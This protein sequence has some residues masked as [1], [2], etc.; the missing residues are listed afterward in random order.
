MGISDDTWA[1]TVLQHYDVPDGG[2][3]CPESPIDAGYA[4]CM[5]PLGSS[6]SPYGEDWPVALHGGPVPDPTPQVV[7]ADPYNQLAWFQQNVW[8]YTSQSS[9]ALPYSPAQ[10][11]PN[12]VAAN[13][14]SDTST[15]CEFLFNIR[16]LDEVEVPVW[17]AG[18]TVMT[19]VNTAHAIACN[20][21]G[22]TLTASTTATGQDFDFAQGTAILDSN[23][24]QPPWGP[25]FLY[26]SLL[27]ELQN[28]DN[29]AQL[30]QVAPGSCCMTAPSLDCSAAVTYADGQTLL[31]PAGYSTTLSFPVQTNFFGTGYCNISVSHIWRDASAA[32]STHD[33]IEQISFVADPGGPVTCTVS[34]QIAFTDIEQSWYVQP[35]LRQPVP[36]NSTALTSLLGG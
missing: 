28:Q 23:H 15:T 34:A 36:A 7:A 19:Y 22:N 29:I 3:P 31:L 10:Y 21:E 1:N 35:G 18:D 16:S 24:S 8:A 30:V 33:F 14:V 20:Y 17:P 2:S 13:V 9:H 27:L 4:T 25:G 32:T 11:S 5:A 26:G 12:T 6:G